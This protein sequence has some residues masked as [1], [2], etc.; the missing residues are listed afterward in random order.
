M[1]FYLQISAFQHHGQVALAKIQKKIVEAVNKSQKITAGDIA[2]MFG[3]SHQSAL[4]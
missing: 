1:I 4:K 3:T 2:A